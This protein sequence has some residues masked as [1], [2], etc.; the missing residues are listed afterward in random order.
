MLIP[1]AVMLFDLG[2]DPSNIEDGLRERAGCIIA[3]RGILIIQEAWKSA[4]G[5]Q[6][7]QGI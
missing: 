3:W 7:G 6:G 4:F 1:Y 5:G 2:N